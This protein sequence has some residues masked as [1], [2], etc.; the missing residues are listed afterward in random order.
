M[1]RFRI[2]YKKVGA[3]R[4]ASHR[5][6]M[7]AFRRGFTAGNVPVCYSQGFNP[8]PRLSFGPSLR[9]GW[10]GLA[11]CMDVMLEEAVADLPA[12]C[13]GCLPEGLE[14]VESVEVGSTA[15][16]LSSDVSAARYEVYIDPANLDSGRNSLWN[17]FLDDAGLAGVSPLDP[18][19]LSALCAHVQAGEEKRAEE[20]RIQDIQISEKEGCMC[21]QY[22][23]TMQQGKSVFPEQILEPLMG[24]MLE[25]E[26]PWRVVR[27][28]LY[29]RR[30]GAY[31]SPT[32]KGVVRAPQ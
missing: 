3:I 10:E 21:V 20:P 7:R 31:H 23:S 17:G 11:E 12:R 14:I 29:V 30:D 19:V 8:H 1:V 27:M 26:V 25:Q 18:R 24:S 9:T 5:D 6:L 32:S 2:R 16:K 15:P 28:N 4:Y 13:N 22:L